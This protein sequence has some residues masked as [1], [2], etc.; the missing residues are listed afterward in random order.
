[1]LKRI[2]IQNR[3]RIAEYCFELYI[4]IMSGSKALGLDRNDKAYIIM[5]LV[6]AMVSGVSI[7]LHKYSVREY[8]I[9]GLLL[10][11]CLYIMAITHQLAPMCLFLTLFSAKGMDEKRITK[12]MFVTWIIGFMLVVLMSIVGIIPNYSRVDMNHGGVVRYAMGYKKDNAFHLSFFIV[13]MLWVYCIEKK[14]A[15][16]YLVFLFANGM[17]FFLSNC[18]AGFIFTIVGIMASLVLKLAVKNAKVLRFINCFMSATWYFPLIITLFT[19]GIRN[20]DWKINRVMNSMFNN[21]IWGIRAA[22]NTYKIGIGPQT[23][24]RSTYIGNLP[25][26]DNAYAYMLLQYGCAFLI[27]YIL[28][29]GWIFWRNG[30]DIICE[31]MVAYIM[32]FYGLVEQFIQNCFMNFS[33]VIIG[34]LVWRSVSKYDFSLKVKK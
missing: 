14:K 10:G 24:D 30:E 20:Q 2:S 19:V 17:A 29:Y 9:G 31:K 3:E 25:G 28:L 7:L 34:C 11:L 23:F 8:L 22:F 27:L 32:L 4:V 12:A 21:R 6:A 1:M 15:W 13:T 16:M 33:L 26:L 18:R 5:G